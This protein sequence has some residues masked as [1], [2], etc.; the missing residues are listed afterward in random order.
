MTEN[1]TGLKVVTVLGIALALAGI[2]AVVVITGD[3]DK[4]KKKSKK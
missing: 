1:N 4:P 2:V 3:D